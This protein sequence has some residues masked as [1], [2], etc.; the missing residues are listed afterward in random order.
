MDSTFA[1]RIGTKGT[2]AVWT[3]RPGDS[4]PAQVLDHGLHK[5]GPAALR[6]QVFVAENQRSAVLRASLRCNPE[7]ARV[8]EVEKT[9]GRWGE[10]SAI[11]D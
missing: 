6:I 3:F 10:A 5:L 1:L 7:R 2:T 9:C 4:E 11:G 8:S